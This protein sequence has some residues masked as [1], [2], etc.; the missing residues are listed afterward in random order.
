MYIYIGISTYQVSCKELVNLLKQVQH[1]QYKFTSANK[2][3]NNCTM[4]L[5][6]NAFRHR[7][8]FIFYWIKI[9]TC[10]VTVYAI[11]NI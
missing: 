9:Y 4:T 10:F 6:L 1:A 7:N 3:I 5:Y 8:F 2:N 11:K